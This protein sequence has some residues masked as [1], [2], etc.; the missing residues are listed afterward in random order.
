LDLVLVM[1]VNP[2]FG[3]QSFIWHTL[4][5]VAAL[6]ALMES[7]GSGALIEVDGGVNLETGQQ[8]LDV[9][10]QA[11]VAGSFVFKAEHPEKQIERLKALNP[12]LK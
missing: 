4:R 6:K 12:V 3:G 7:A 10:A 9:G 5:K 2:G 8:L 11:L 1:S